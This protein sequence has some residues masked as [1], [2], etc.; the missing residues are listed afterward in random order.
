M[1]DTTDIWVI[2]AVVLSII[3]PLLVFIW[4]MLPWITRV[5]KSELSP[6]NAKVA[7]IEGI[8]E[9]FTKEQNNRMTR[10]EDTFKEQQKQFIDLYIEVKKIKNPDTE[11]GVLLT[12]LKSDTIT[13]V[14]ATRLQQIMNAKKQEAEQN[15]DFLT[16]ILIIGI[17]ALIAY[18]LAH[19]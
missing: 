5:V 4:G 15:N 14:E 17:L 11:E 13:K 10:L 9:I 18:V 6:L 7:K 19:D 1:S 3:I 12:K 16:A 2:V 8:L